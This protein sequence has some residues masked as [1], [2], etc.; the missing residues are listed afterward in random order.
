M[1]EIQRPKRHHA[2]LH[3][4]NVDSVQLYF[5]PIGHELQGRYYMRGGICFP[6][7]IETVGGAEIRGFALMA[8]QNV[9]TGQVWIFEQTQFICVRD[10]YDRNDKL[11]HEGITSWFNSVWNS[12]LARKYYWHQDSNT[13][14]KYLLQLLK[15]PMLNPKPQ[16]IEAFWNDEDQA[17]HSMMEL[18]ATNRLKYAPD[19][20]LDKAEKAHRMNRKIFCPEVHALLCALWGFERHPW[21]NR[22]AEF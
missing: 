10:A 3:G 8:G 14:K 22:D 21:R 2:I 9:R 11:L 4:D 17:E 6:S 12:Y 7:L 19:S 15:A 5:D 20:P 18:A 16:L 13:K 1:T